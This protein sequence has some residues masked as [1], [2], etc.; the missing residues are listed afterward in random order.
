MKFHLMVST[1]AAEDAILI[2]EDVF[3][4]SGR[5]QEEVDH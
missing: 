2:D 3:S 5:K 1:D 4:A